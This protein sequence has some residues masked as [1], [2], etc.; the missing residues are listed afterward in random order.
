MAPPEASGSALEGRAWTR[1]WWCVNAGEI[2]LGPGIIDGIGL[3]LGYI[4]P[5]STLIKWF[6]ERRGMATGLAIMGFGGGAMIGAPLADDLINAFRSPTSV[7]AWQAL[8]TLSAVYL[9]FML[10]GAFRR[11]ENQLTGL[12]VCSP[13]AAKRFYVR[14]ALLSKEILDG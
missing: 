13:L 8:T 5:V 9:A 6:P 7:G 14:K 4:S 3:G 2:L 10:A 1:T 12:A 11:R